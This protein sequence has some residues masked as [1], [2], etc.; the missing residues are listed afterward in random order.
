[1]AL[2]ATHARLPGVDNAWARAYEIVG[3]EHRRNGRV[4]AARTAYTR[5]L[6]IRPDRVYARRMLDLPAAGG[7]PSP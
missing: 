3:D 5:A 4:A 6:Q 7:D 2:I 1:D